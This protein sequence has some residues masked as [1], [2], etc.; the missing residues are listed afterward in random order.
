MIQS[1]LFGAL[2]GLFLFWCGPSTAGG[3]GAASQLS[4]EVARVADSIHW[5]GHASVRID[6]GGLVVY[7]DP[8]QLG[9][10]PK[11]ADL[12][13][14]THDHRDHCSPED[15]EAVFREGT[16]IVTIA[17]AAEKLPGK[18]VQ[19]VTPGDKITVKGLSIEAVPA[20]NL[21][22]FRSPGVPFHPK[23]ALHVGFVVTLDGVR[24]YHSGDT[25]CIP[26]M[27]DV[28]AD[29]VL[30]PVSGKYV[31]TAEEA[32]KAVEILR[33]A[34]AI[35]MHVGR[36]IGSPEDAER[37]RELSPLPVRVLPME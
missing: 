32:V 2:F 22:K 20:Y 10:E 15:V 17:A 21:N 27:K 26:E 35:P 37:F 30:L 16:E 12:V 7:I 13:L 5:L 4:A 14:I 8:W 31:M 1:I 33:P 19:I 28:R 29:I 9:G 25:D 23:E 11:K 18:P 3:A 6:A 34:L 24:I 36:G